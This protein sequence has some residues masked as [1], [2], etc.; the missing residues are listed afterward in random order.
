[1]PQ[2][3]CKFK[4]IL[5][6]FAFSMK[7][8]AK[9]IMLELCLLR[10]KHAQQRRPRDIYYQNYLFVKTNAQ[11]CLLIWFRNYSQNVQSKRNRDCCTRIRKIFEYIHAFTL[12]NHETKK[13]KKK[14]CIKFKRAYART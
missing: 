10:V 9:I 3:F 14:H 4:K 11:N 6:R 1:M 13:N 5:L 7:R 2:H 12:H 8:L